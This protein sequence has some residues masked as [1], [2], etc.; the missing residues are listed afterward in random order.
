[1]NYEDYYNLGVLREEVPIKKGQEVS[2]EVLASFFATTAE[3]SMLLK[4]NNLTTALFLEYAAN[5]GTEKVKKLI[6][7]KEK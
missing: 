2:F 7:T 6:I 1:M 4:M 5:K 3:K